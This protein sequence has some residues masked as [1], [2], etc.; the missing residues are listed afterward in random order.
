MDAPRAMRQLRWLLVTL[1]VIGCALP[2][3]VA[4]PP[5]SALSTRATTLGELI[6]PVVAEHP[7]ESGFVLFNTGEGAHS[8]AGGAGRCRRSRAS[9]PSTFMWAGDTIGRVL[10]ERLIA[11]AD[12]GVRVRLLIDD[13]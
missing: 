1:A 10:L 5:S 9:T 3:N 11:A 4:R 2:K 12:R 8:G 6:A 7:G 13:Y